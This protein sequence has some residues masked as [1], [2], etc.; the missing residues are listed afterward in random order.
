MKKLM[1]L[2][3]LCAMLLAGCDDDS[4]TS[5][6]DSGQGT[7]DSTA[8]AAADE[9]ADESQVSSITE[10][11][12]SADSSQKSDS[13]DDTS[14]DT[15]PDVTT[16]QTDNNSKPPVVTAGDISFAPQSDTQSKAEIVTTTVTYSGD[17][18]AETSAAKQTTSAEKQTTSGKTTSKSA[19][20]T[21]PNTTGSSKP[22][23]T[24]FDNDEVELPLIPVE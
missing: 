17:S 4:S 19:E 8:S 21:T 23:N 1:V 11:S 22:D 16:V 15:K 9:T 10:R 5:E 20:K 14:D 6:I 7:A 13:L 2:F 12:I 3:L 18:E 24:S